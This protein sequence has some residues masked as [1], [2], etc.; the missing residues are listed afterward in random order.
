MKKEYTIPVEGKVATIKDP[1]GK[2]RDI[3]TVL[4]NVS[5]LPKDFPLEVNPRS[6]DTR[7]RVAKEIA[8]SFVDE[9]DE[10]YRLNRGITIIPQSMEIKSHKGH[11][12][13]TLR[14]PEHSQRYGV[15]DGGHSYAV[16]REMTEEAENGEASDVY[17]QLRIFENVTPSFITD[18]ARALNTSAQVR[19]ESLA[20][21]EGLFDWI[22]EALKGSP[23][24]ELIAYRENEDK[25]NDIR[26]VIAI[27][28]M[29]HPFFQEEENP[30]V[31]AYTSKG[32]C[33]DM[34]RDEQ[35]QN[36]YQRLKSILVDCLRLY[37]YIHLKF[38][39]LYKE[40]GGM[41]SLSADAKTK[42]D[43][44][45]VKL[46]KLTEVKHIKDGFPLYYLGEKAT[47]RFPDGWLYPV[48][49]SFR[50]LLSYRGSGQVKWKTNPFEFFDKHGKK[51]IAMT[52]NSSREM[53]RNPNA[54][55]KNKA[56]WT[57]LQDK[58]ENL[59]IKSLPE[60]EKEMAK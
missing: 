40:M 14:F 34:F 7:S 2:G 16:I 33:L 26:E 10:F 49:A 41:S 38:E 25:P 31:M 6:Q 21:L 53:G 55:G 24:E 57:Q 32:R 56:H 36:G 52:L 11:D 43:Q 18:L 51:L 60:V 1:L 27:L 8:H 35:H 4:V 59:F 13:I 12:E 17:V 48:L 28:T 47:Y 54:V 20:N 58:V 29:F 46:G 37:D 5:N 3:H 22:K 39:P 9:A 42:K 15:I 50:P 23:F 45:G 44:K 19:D 30:P